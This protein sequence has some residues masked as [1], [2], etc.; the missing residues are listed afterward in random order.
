MCADENTQEILLH[1]TVPQSIVRQDLSSRHEPTKKS[2]RR[3]KKVS[4]TELESFDYDRDSTNRL[5]R[6][7]HF[8]IIGTLLVNFIFGVILNIL[9][10]WKFLSLRNFP[11]EATEYFTGL[12]VSLLLTIK[13]NC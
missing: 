10:V 8:F 1:T 4:R 12:I 7:H 6:S 2:L 5:A 9:S 13:E 11:T 3:S